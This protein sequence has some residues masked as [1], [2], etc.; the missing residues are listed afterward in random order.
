MPDAMSTAT[1]KQTM[2]PF[3]FSAANTNYPHT[4]HDD[5]ETPLRFA[6]EDVYAK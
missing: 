5:T 3:P 6:R 4:S 2:T 1:E